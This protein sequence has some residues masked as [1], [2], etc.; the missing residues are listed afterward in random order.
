MDERERLVGFLSDQVKGLELFWP[1]DYHSSVDNSVEEVCH[2]ALRQMADEGA[3]TL[4]SW[5]NSKTKKE[6]Q[7]TGARLTEEFKKKSF[8]EFF[9][10]YKD[11]LE[12]AMQNAG[13]TNDDYSEKLLDELRD[14]FNRANLPYKIKKTRQKDDSYY[15]SY[16]LIPSKTVKKRKTS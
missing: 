9:T 4:Y 12:V 1:Q 10:L 3:V 6:Y 14:E 11:S 16:D 5:Y 13:E 8:D 2:Q 15:W 7:I